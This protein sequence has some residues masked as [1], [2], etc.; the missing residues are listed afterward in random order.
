MQP[1]VISRHPHVQILM[2]MPVYL[3][4]EESVLLLQMLRKLMAN[5][6][7]QFSPEI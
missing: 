6:A 7:A 4:V 5:T 1:K 3:S 2:V